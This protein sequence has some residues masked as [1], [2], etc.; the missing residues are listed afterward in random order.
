M[1]WMNFNYTHLKFHYNFRPMKN[2]KFFESAKVLLCL[3]E[4]WDL[5]KNCA[6]NDQKEAH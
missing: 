3:N 1:L 4:G 6:L 5:F 2:V